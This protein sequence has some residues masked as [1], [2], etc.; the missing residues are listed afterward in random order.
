M[1]GHLKVLGVSGVWAWRISHW[2]LVVFRVWVS[3][4]QPDSFQGLGSGFRLLGFRV[5]RVYGLESRVW[6]LGLRSRMF[7]LPQT[8][9]M[10]FK[11]F[12]LSP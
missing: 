12:S 1:F 5:F 2:G 11:G 8:M 7:L 4:I 10:G 9:P 6:G 3:G